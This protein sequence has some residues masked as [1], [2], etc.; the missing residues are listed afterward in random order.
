MAWNET[1]ELSED[2]GVIGWDLIDDQTED[3]TRIPVLA[4]AGGTIREIG[5]DEQ[6]R[7]YLVV[8]SSEPWGSVRSTAA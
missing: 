4:M 3:R 5:E 8:D 1:H 6:G 2:Y 7:R